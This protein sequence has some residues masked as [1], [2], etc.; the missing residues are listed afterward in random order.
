MPPLFAPGAS[1]I[2]LRGTYAA[3]PTAGIQG[4]IYFCTDSL[5]AFYDDGSNWQ[6]V[7][8]NFP[9]TSTPAVSGFS[10]INAGGRATT[11][12]DSKGGILL[13]AA[14]GVS[15]DDYRLIKKAAPAAPYTLTVHF[16]PMLDYRNYSGAG[17]L[18]RQSSNGSCT[19]FGVIQNTGGAFLTRNE[20]ASGTGASPTFTLSSDIVSASTN[21][22]IRYGAGVWLRLEDDNT[23]RKFHYST[24]GQNWIQLASV[25]RTSFITP[26]EIGL[27][28]APTVVAGTGTQASAFFDSWVTV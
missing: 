18:W 10:A 26:D 13:S 24:D 21:E 16:W 20:T 19:F 5:L 11:A 8:P 15:A 22:V 6:P 27:W 28:I 1:S 7:G 3:R 9:L 17:I 14:N 23:N 25:L 4:R 2:N 12:S